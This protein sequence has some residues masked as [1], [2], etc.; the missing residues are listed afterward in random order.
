MEL[1]IEKKTIIDLIFLLFI[2][3]PSFRFIGFEMSFVGTGTPSYIRI[4][5]LLALIVTGFLYFVKSKYKKKDL[6]ILIYCGYM[7]LISLYMRLKGADVAITS[8]LSFI[9]SYLGSIYLIRSRGYKFIDILFIFFTII[10]LVETIVLLTPLNNSFKT[11]DTLTFIGHIQ[12]YSMLWVTYISLALIKLSFIENDNKKYALNVKKIGIVIM[13]LISTVVAWLSGV[14]AAKIVILFF[15]VLLFFFRNKVLNSAKWLRVFFIVSMI[16]NVLILFFNYQNHFPFLLSLIGGD[17]TLNGRTYIWSLFIPLLLKSP[18]FGYGYKTQGVILSNWGHVNNMDYCH[19]TILQELI[20]GG[21]IQLILFVIIIFKTISHAEKC[22]NNA[23][24]HIA[25]C[26]LL[27][28]FVI[29]ITESIT[30]YNYFNVLL[31]IFMNFDYISL[32]K[33]KLKKEK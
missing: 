21:V 7:L 33:K 9:T 29:M 6:P 5:S 20:H 17:A 28:F 11:S 24:Y 32:S 15:L 16:I 8:L 27:S 14:I 26:C 30:Y 18:I 22:K 12:I 31:A 3:Y 19:N 13:L 2:F 4:W 10:I 1:K 23:L 25:F